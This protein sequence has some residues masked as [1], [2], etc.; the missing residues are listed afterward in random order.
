MRRA[1]VLAL[2]ALGLAFASIPQGVG[3]SENAHF[4]TVKAIAH[5]KAY[6]DDFRGTPPTGDVAWYHGHYYSTKAPGLALLTAG[7]Y[8]LMHGLGV[9]D[10][11][12]SLPGARTPEVG[13]LW[14]LTIIGCAIPLL[15]ALFL[16]RRIG[17]ELAPGFG[18]AGAVSIGLG[19]LLLPFATLFF[20]HALSASLGFIAFAILWWRRAQLRYCALAGLAAGYAVTSEYPLGVVAIALGLYVLL[21]APAGARLGRAGAYAA[22]LAVGV[23]PIVI[24]NWWAF[25]TPT[26]ITYED[27]VS[28]LGVS[29][30]DVLHANVRGFFGVYW[31]SFHVAMRLLFTNI[32][33]LTLAPIA[34]V[35]AAGAVLLQRAGHRAEALL[36]GGLPLA[37]VVYNS[38]YE[39]PLGGWSPGPRF[40]VAILP[41][42]A[43]PLALAYREWPLPTLLLTL[44]SATTMTMITVSQPI[45]AHDGSWYHRVFN[46]HFYN[47]GVVA[48]VPFAVFLVAALVLT[49][50]ATH[51][52]RLTRQDVVGGVAAFAGWLLL[53]FAA[54]RLLRESHAGY[55]LLLALAV[56]GAVV[57]AHRFSRPRRFSSSLE[58]A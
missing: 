10:L 26:H 15:V 4:G 22:G 18:T 43:I 48:V 47:H 2:I 49:V 9:V 52:R 13:T 44:G 24:F 27:A 51:R 3:W 54:P 33:L 7:P 21:T 14:L 8:I 40:L 20:D 16:L 11:A 55:V 57:A 6:I 39:D 37:F 31:P 38:G 28:H 30:H 58:P 19:S 34:A 5:G 23:L 56:I 25:G 41:F 53:A 42:L 35:G 45:S 32:G 17:D 29:G 36:V 12:G 46:G 50:T 1:G